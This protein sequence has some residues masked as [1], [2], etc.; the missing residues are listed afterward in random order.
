MRPDCIGALKYSGPVFFLHR[1][2]NEIYDSVSMSARPL[3][4]A[5]RADFLERYRLREP[6]YRQW[7]DYVI[8]AFA[9]PEQTAEAILEVLK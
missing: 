4:Q 3:G 5:G 7:A 2:G 1:D 6:V 8:E 9:S